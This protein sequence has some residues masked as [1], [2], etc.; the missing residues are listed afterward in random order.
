MCV[1]KKKKYKNNDA[2]EFYGVFPRKKR[3][4]L[5]CEI[6]EYLK[7]T[8]GLHDLVFNDSEYDSFDSYE[9]GLELLF[10]VESLQI[11]LLR[12]LDEFSNDIITNAKDIRA[13]KRD[14]FKLEESLLPFAIQLFLSN[15]SNDPRTG[16]RRLLFIAEIIETKLKRKIQRDEFIALNY[17]RRRRKI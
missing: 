16:Q 1:E 5:K 4:D 14:I 9:E 3:D 11:E 12:R 7:D 15:F 6:Y 10:R 13:I 2:D 17:S 8:P